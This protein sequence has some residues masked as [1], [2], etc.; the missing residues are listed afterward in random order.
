LI[1]LFGSPI[2]AQ[3]KAG[4]S[5]LV[6]EAPSGGWKEGVQALVAELLTSGYELTVRAAGTRSLDQ[7]E[8][9]LEREV[10]QSGVSAVVSVTRT[11]SRGSAWLCRRGSPCERLDVEIADRELSR[12]RLA[13]AVVERLRP[14][15]LLVTVPPP[16][17]PRPPVEPAADARTRVEPVGQ[18]G[19]RPFRVWVGGGSVVSSGLAAPLPWLSASLGAMLSAP[20]GLEVGIAGAPLSGTTQSYAGSLSLRALSG[21]GFATFEPFPRRT[22]GLSLGLGGG[23]IHLRESANPAAGFDGF[24]RSATVA[25]VSARARLQYRAGP[26]YLG[27]ALDPGMLVPALKVQ[28][29]TA[30]VLR[31]GRPW[32][33]LQASLG[34]TL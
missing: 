6:L 13:L 22:V 21:M 32:V 18:L 29:G 12:S 24:S 1:C 9:E 25:V 7:L 28:A 20:W 34:V 19:E 26:V 17:A 31:I 23:T 3:P 33:T 11:D 30:T 4:A 8:K 14:I 16:N 2:A 10:V 15:D 5:V 27:L